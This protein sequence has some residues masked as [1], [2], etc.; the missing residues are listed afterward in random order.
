[1]ARDTT[2]RLYLGISLLMLALVAPLLGFLVAKTGWS[3]AAKATVIGLLTAGIPELLGILAAAVLGKKNFERIKAQVFS[4]LKRLRPTGRVSRTRY[5]VGLV[6]FIL[7][8]APTYVMAYLPQWLPDASSARLYVNIAADC[9][10]ISSLFVLGG[11]FWD[12]LAALFI[13]DSQPQEDSGSAA[14]VVGK[15]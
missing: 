15:P 11:D 3:V 9:M 10:F 5:R 1:M 2:V 6:M 7:P 13:H 12:K 14:Q 8:I 4:I